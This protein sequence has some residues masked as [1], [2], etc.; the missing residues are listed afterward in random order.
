MCE[1]NNGPK[2]KDLKP[3]DRKFPLSSDYVTVVY[4][5]EEKRPMILV[6]NEVFKQWDIMSSRVDKETEKNFDVYAHDFSIVRD[7]SGGQ[8]KYQV[9]TLKECEFTVEVTAEAIPSIDSYIDW[10]K[11]NI[12]R[13]SFDAPH[14]MEE[15]GGDDPVDPKPSFLNNAD[16]PAAKVESKGGPNKALLDAAFMAI[17]KPFD[18][19]SVAICQQKILKERLANLGEGADKNVDLD[20]M[21]DIELVKFMSLYKEETKNIK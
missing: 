18:S 8:T 1:V 5:Y 7:D 20:H 6:G 15:K 16:Q 4:V 21:S 17:T 11:S 13:V 12:E 9:V 2:Y 19:T 14:K 3:R 10:M